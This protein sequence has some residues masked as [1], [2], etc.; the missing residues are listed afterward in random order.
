VPSFIESFLAPRR[1]PGPGTISI[2]VVIRLPLK[3]GARGIFVPVCGALHGGVPQGTERA[4]EHG[5]DGTQ[6]AQGE[7]ETDANGRRPR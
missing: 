6:G 7:R 5:G 1:S 3:K 4:A 2:H